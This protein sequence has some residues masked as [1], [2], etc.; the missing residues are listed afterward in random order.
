M[1]D[2]EPTAATDKLLTYKEIAEILNVSARTIYSLDLPVI[3]ITP[4]APRVLQSAL[5]DWI[6]SRGNVGQ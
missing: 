5:Q 3:Y 2:K 4:S 1:D 6:D